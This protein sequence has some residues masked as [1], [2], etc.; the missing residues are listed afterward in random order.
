MKPTFFKAGADF[1]RWLKA[2]HSKTPELLLGFYKKELGRGITYPEALD[3]ALAFGWIDG[4][5]KRCDEKSY[6]IRFTPRKSKSIWSQVNIKRV[7]E[8][9]EL[10]RMEAA[11]LRAFE[12]RDEARTKLYSYEREAAK[13]DAEMS[14]TL[15]ANAKAVAFFKDQPPGYQRLATFWIMSAKK[16][17]TRSMRMEILVAKSAR[18]ER[19]D[20]LRPNRL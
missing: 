17:E 11:G 10:G 16:P 7:K 14:A 12:T 13:L 1:R 4:V 18:G 9:I 5:R 6:T 8:L 3:E 2:N 19:L 15:H 20:P